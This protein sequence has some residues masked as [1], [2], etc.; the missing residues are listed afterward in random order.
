MKY[1]DPHV[2]CGP[3]VEKVLELAEKQGIAAIF[4]MP[5]TD[6]P[7]LF[8]KDAIAR[9][10]LAK[11]SEVPVKYFLYIGLTAKE[12]QIKG[13]VALVN[14]YPQ[15]VGLKLYT[16]EAGKLG[17]SRETDQAKIYKC[18]AKLGY[19]GVLAVHCEKESLFA[20]ELFKPWEPWTWGMARPA[21]SEYESIKDQIEFTERA[22]FQGA[23]HICHVSCPE[24]VDLIWHA[25]NYLDITC[26]VTPHHLLFNMADISGGIANIFYKVN[27]PIRDKKRTQELFKRLKQGKIDWLET[28]HAPYTWEEKLKYPF[29][30][31]IAG[32]NFYQHCLD[33]L[34]GEGLTERELAILTYWNIKK[35]FGEKLRGV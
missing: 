25:K 10:E 3:T 30:S 24:S 16:A 8:E 1:I 17:V 27:P 11:A 19:Q 26:G 22:G 2:H 31:G 13:A 28:D 35:V 14:Q 12:E 4:D 18:L 33:W 5:D 7:I 9:L 34:K 15:V 32:M 20:P 6:P 21:E 29:P 23:L